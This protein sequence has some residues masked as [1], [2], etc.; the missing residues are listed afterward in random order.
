MRL[1]LFSILLCLATPLRAVGPDLYG[2]PYAFTD[3]KGRI[4]HLSDWRGK[5]AVLTME[6]A[7]CRFICSITLQRMRDIQD[8][9]E[10][11]GQTFEFL[12]LS[13][14]PENDTPKAWTQY[15]KKRGLNRDNWHFLTAAP[16]P[17][18]HGNSPRCWGSN[19]GITMST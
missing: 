17:R 10:R 12:I 2:L 16:A 3:D 14:D 8:E 1:L 5:P 19:T 18:K 6:Y 13:I 7:N 9:A 15:R 11:R 4:A